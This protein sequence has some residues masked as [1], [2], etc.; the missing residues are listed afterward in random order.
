[1]FSC[2]KSQIPESEGN[3]SSRFR[4]L[5]ETYISLEKM[6][7]IIAKDSSWWFDDQLYKQS[8]YS[9]ELVSDFKTERTLRLNKMLSSFK[10]IAFCSLWLSQS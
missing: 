10:E 1:M 7:E 6:R 4:Q 3:G 5:L 8:Q 9:G 2:G